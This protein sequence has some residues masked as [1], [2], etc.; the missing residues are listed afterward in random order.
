MKPPAGRSGLVLLL[1]TEVDLARGLCK[2]DLSQFLTL[3]EWDSLADSGEVSGE[4]AAGSLLSVFVG[5][6]VLV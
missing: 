4:T 3:V 2:R 1:L 5:Q 6:V